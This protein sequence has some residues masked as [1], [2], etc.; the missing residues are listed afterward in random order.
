MPNLDHISQWSRK[1]LAKFIKLHYLGRQDPCISDIKSCDSCNSSSRDPT[2]FRAY[3]HFTFCLQSKRSHSPTGD[4]CTLI[5][6]ARAKIK[7]R[8]E[9]GRELR[10][11]TVNR[12]KMAAVRRQTTRSTQYFYRSIFRSPF[13]LHGL[14]AWM[15]LVGMSR[16][17]AE[18]KAE[19]LECSTG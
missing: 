19:N 14:S 7:W 9:L 1:H 18:E 12:E 5:Q 11:Q 17:K 10:R 2:S 3:F 6:K 8:Q 13:P 16:W 4:A 15:R